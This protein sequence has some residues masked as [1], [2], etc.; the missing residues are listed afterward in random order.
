MRLAIFWPVQVYFDGERYTT[1]GFAHLWFGPLARHFEAVDL[2]VPMM[3][4]TTRRGPATLDT[5]RIRVLPLPSASRGWQLYTTHLPAII[6]SML[7]MLRAHR[8]QWDRVLIYEVQPLSQIWYALTKL[9]GLNITLYLGGRHEE[10]LLRRNSERGFILRTLANIWARW[11]RLIVPHLTQGAPTVVT[12]RHLV[13]YYAG[14]GKQRIHSIPSSSVRQSEIVA[15]VNG[16]GARAGENDVPLIVSVC[17][18][19]PVK[20]LEYLIEAMGVLK[21]IGRPTRLKVAGRKDVRYER[22]LLELANARGIADAVEFLGPISPGQELRDLYDEGDVFV[23][24][25]LSEGTPKVVIEAMSRGVPVVASN[26]GGIPDLIEHLQ[27]GML[28]PPGQSDHL[29]WAIER[30]LG[31][32]DLRHRLAEGALASAR[33][34]T[35]EAQTRQLADV[36][37]SE[38]AIV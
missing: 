13:E 26:V 31:D 17:R 37:R 5:S 27:T 14:N 9:A 18:V 11:C 6:I 16:H 15:A 8:K 3:N 25:S 28:V 20:G 21:S 2:I 32:E 7:R 29:A 4:T 19:T 23:L 22:Y 24:P 35:V 38:G 33:T 10:A 36:L 1:N 12:G 34:L 30:L